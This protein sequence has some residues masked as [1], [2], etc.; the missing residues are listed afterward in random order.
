MITAGG[1]PAR[2]GLVVPTLGLRPDF[3]V[4]TL[5][6]IADQD[7]AVHTVLVGP[8]SVLEVAEEFGADYLP[9][10]G[11][12]SAA[13]NVG[14]AAMPGGVEFVGWLGD[15]DLLVQH[16][17]HTVASLLEA[18]PRA[19]A[20]FGVC[21]YV[22]AS[23]RLVWT[24]KLRRLAVTASKIGPNLIPQPGSLIRRAAWQRIGGLDEGLRFT[25]DLDIFL[26]LEELGPIVSSAQTVAKFRWHPDS[27]TVS[28]R[29]ASLQEAYDV[30][31]MHA[32]RG[33]KWLVTLAYRPTVWATSA[34]ARKVQQ[35]AQSQ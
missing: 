12:I 14:V 9:D 33:L 29:A 10:P 6:S 8:P 22:D 18:H 15:D 27:T 32:G 2:V 17:V 7:V 1:K 35:K 21:E 3:L 13:I 23:G 30:R 19:T 28:G 25:M 20:G 26:R 11:G 5:R 16:S 4:Q 24:S 31:R 34:S